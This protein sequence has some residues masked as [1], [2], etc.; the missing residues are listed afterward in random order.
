MVSK[1]SIKVKAYHRGA[2]KVTSRVES[3]KVQEFNSLMDEAV[4]QPG[5]AIPSA[6][7]QQAEQFEAGL[8]AIFDDHVGL[9]P[10]PLHAVV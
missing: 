10:A 2:S 5:D 9:L 7:W 3:S 4:P 1:S 6:R 8:I